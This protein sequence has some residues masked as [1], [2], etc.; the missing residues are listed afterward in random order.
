MRFKSQDGTLI[1][2]DRVQQQQ[3]EL[4]GFDR[5]DDVDDDNNYDNDNKYPEQDLNNSSNISSV[6]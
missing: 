3:P 4:S 2:S 6:I 5:N 1:K